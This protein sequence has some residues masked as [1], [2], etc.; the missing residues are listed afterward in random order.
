MAARRS[1]IE[2]VLTG[3]VT[4]LKNST[5]VT[6]LVSTRVYN[7]VPQTQDGGP[8]PYLVVTSPTDRREDT[9]GRFGASVLVDVKA[10]SQY[11]GDKE[12]A[13]ILDHCRR[14]L[15]FVQPTVSGHAILGMT[16]ENGDRFLEVVNGI[17][18]RHHVDTFRVWTEQSSS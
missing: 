8:Y 4:T 9:M 14:A 3:I 13:Q 17:P 15:N 1:P 16:W 6:G 2:A 12:A 7:N 11:Q 5:G 18:T 10:V